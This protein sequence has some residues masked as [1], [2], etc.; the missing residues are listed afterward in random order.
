MSKLF[1]PISLRKLTLD[2]RIVVSPM[3]QYS[4]CE[5]S[6]TDWHL[7]HLGSMSLE[8]FREVLSG[9]FDPMRK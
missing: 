2:N 5:G 7:M 1:S 3:C 6:A 8:Q 4:A 9:E